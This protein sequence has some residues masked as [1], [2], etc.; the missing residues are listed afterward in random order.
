MT[1]KKK[2]ICLIGSVA[3]L[4]ITAGSAFALDCSEAT[5]VQVGSDPAIAN[6]TRSSHVVTLDC[7]NDTKW[8]GNV[9]FFLTPELGD[10][11]LAVLLTAKSLGKSVLARVSSKTPG[12]LVTIVY[13]NNTPSL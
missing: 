1:I 7:H 6:Q 5:V 3:I 9:Q 8:A 2:I 10:S 13:L 12:S 11:G 4:A